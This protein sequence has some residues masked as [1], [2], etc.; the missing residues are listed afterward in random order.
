MDG[1]AT[2]TLPAASFVDDVI[3]NNDGNTVRIAVS[4]LV[5]LLSAL[6]GPT[7]ATRAQLAADLAWPDGAVGY[8]R[9]DPNS[10][11]NGVYKKSGAAGGGSWGRIGDLPS[12]ALEQAAIDELEQELRIFGT[13]VYLSRDQAVTRVP[14]DTDGMAAVLV[15]EGTALQLRSRNSTIDPLFPDAADPWGTALPPID[16]EA[17]RLQRIAVDETERAERI[18]ADAAAT[19]TV[20]RE[21]VTT[22]LS[23]L[24]RAIHRAGFDAAPS[25]EVTATSPYRVIIAQSGA[26]GA[27]ILR[28]VLVAAT[29]STGTGGLIRLGAWRP[30]GNELVLQREVVIN[31]ASQGTG[32][33]E[34]YTALPIAAGEYPGIDMSDFGPIRSG[35]TA[36]STWGAWRGVGS[37]PI[38]TTDVTSARTQLVFGVLVDAY[39]SREYVDQGNAARAAETE[40]LDGRM[41]V[42]E[43][44]RALRLA[45]GAHPG[46]PAILADDA[47]GNAVAWF[48][49]DG[50]LVVRLADGGNL[51]I[52][53]RQHP[54]DPWV[55]MEDLAGA[56]L[57][58]FEPDGTPGGLFGGAGGAGAGISRPR[59]PGW[60]GNA[61][62]VISDGVS[63]RWLSDAYL[64]QPI[65]FERR[66]SIDLAE[67]GETAVGVIAYGGG[68]GVPHDL[69][70]TWEWHVR[71]PDLSY[72]GSGDAA[73][74]AAAIAQSH[75]WRM[76]LANPTMIALTVAVG[77]PVEADLAV[78][79]PAYAS[80]LAGVTAAAAALQ[81]WGK[82]LSVDRV[83]ISALGGAPNTSR[84]AADYHYAVVAQSL[85]MDIVELTGQGD[86]PVMVVSQSFGSRTDGASTVA[87]AEGDL[88][89]LHPTIGFVVVGPRWVYPLVPGSAATL[90]PEGAA[91]LRELAAL[92]VIE[93]QAGRLWYHPQGQP[94]SG[95]GTTITV[96]FTSMTDLVLDGLDHGFDLEGVTNGAVITAVAVSGKQATL[97]L[98]AVPTGTLWVRF[99]WGRTGDPGDG[100]AANRGGVRDQYGAPSILDPDYIHRRWALSFR[101]PVN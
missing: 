38:L 49:A 26:P 96:P 60:R 30:V 36:G 84:A 47:A 27:G 77:S 100:R 6:M 70:E 28:R 66:G 50:R 4:R 73:E 54:G 57:L 67:T 52:A 18:A 3:G 32:D 9:G 25:V 41:D 53:E 2:T 90:T 45:A 33:L 68:M 55:V 29:R 74:A 8:V 62:Q 20:R 82:T 85:R 34:L 40:A 22:L 16:V 91:L 58:W 75:L 83:E 31:A 56:A 15:R 80:V 48:D 1:V 93:R 42:L 81:P 51:V 89:R 63:I 65:G 21:D 79:S 43:A 59:L 44:E 37:A 7:Y 24:P 71:R 35:G 92:A 13:R 78:V 86:P 98:S 14:V 95:A 19:L 94:A 46:D 39:A 5:A 69:V 87:L 76:G 72:E 11:F 61:W 88:D 99:A 64:G 10:A 12:G 101:V 17:E 97:T 23:A